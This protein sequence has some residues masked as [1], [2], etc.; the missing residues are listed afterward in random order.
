MNSSA[1]VFLINKNVMAFTALYEEG[2]KVET[3]KTFDKTIK[4]GDIVVVE[5]GTRLRF[6]TVKVLAVNVG[7]DIDD[8][9]LKVRWMAGGPIDS[10]SHEKIVSQEADAVERV[11]VAEF[12]KRRRDLMENMVGAE[13]ID[14]IKK[15]PL[16]ANGK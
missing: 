14:A 5:S 16:Y 12:N 4:K 13:D 3:F 1:T 11:K 7:V 10:E 9:N 8:P 6:T 15:L 2:G